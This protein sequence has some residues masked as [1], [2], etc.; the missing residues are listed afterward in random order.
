M[1][2]LII[3]D[4]VLKSNDADYLSLS[5]PLG[6]NPITSIALFAS[7]LGTNI[8]FLLMIRHIMQCHLELLHFGKIFV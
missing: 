1:I 3:Q 5:N 2:D 7:Q 8:L 6:P 4:F